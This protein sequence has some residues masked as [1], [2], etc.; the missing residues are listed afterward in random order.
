MDDITALFDR[1]DSYKKCAPPQPTPFAFT[2]S[3]KRLYALAWPQGLWVCA[4]LQ[5][6]F[7]F[8]NHCLSAASAADL[9]DDG[10]LLLDGIHLEFTDRDRLDDDD[11][12]LVTAAGRRYRGKGR[13][14][15]MR[16]YRPYHVPW[17]L[18]EADAATLQSA[19]IAAER[20]A[21][22]GWPEQG[23]PTLGPRGGLRIEPLPDALTPQYPRLALQNEMLIARL[24]RLPVRASA[25]DVTVQAFPFPTSGEEGGDR[26]D[27]NDKI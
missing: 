6:L 20:L 12:A 3:G 10:M 17:D 1:I 15:Q 16:R 22:Q 21:Q 13:W 18:D 9:W 11:Y 23:L 25:W 2:C 4:D 14:P 27:E 5:H 19:L 8:K 24:R 7:G 26:F